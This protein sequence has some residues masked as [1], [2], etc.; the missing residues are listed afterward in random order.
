M[1]GLRLRFERTAEG[2]QQ[3]YA[4]AAAVEPVVWYDLA[5]FPE[6]DQAQ[7]IERLAN[8]LQASLH[9]GKGR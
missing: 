2:W 1:N 6:D 3:R 9:L 4:E 8:Q 5:S 7:E